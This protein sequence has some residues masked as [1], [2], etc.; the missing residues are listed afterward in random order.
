M[1]ETLW[2]ILGILCFLWIIS[3]LFVWFI[4]HRKLSSKN[5]QK[6]P[7]TI[8]GYQPKPRKTKGPIA[9]PPRKP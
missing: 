6:N 5:E 8:D 3:S 1:N 9:R 2:W 7:N 4:V